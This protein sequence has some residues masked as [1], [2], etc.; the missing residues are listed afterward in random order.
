MTVGSYQGE[1]AQTE[2]E[3]YDI[4]GNRKQNKRNVNVHERPYQPE[5]KIEVN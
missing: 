2:E 4:L 5:P 3:R 1:I